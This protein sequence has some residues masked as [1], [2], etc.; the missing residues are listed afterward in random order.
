[1]ASNS[2]RRSGAGCWVLGAGL[3]MSR[4]VKPNSRSNSSSRARSS[5]TRQLLHHEIEDAICDGDLGG[6]GDFGRLA[7][8]RDHQHFVLIGVESDRGIRDVI[9]HDQIRFLAR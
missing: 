5:V 4:W 6:P 7:V 9:G 3:E 2:P 1:M 8:A